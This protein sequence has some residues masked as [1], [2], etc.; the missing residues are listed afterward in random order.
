M[1]PRVVHCKLHVMA[2]AVVQ[3]N[4][5]CLIVAVN[6]AEHVSYSAEAI[7]GPLDGGSLR[8]KQFSSVG[9]TR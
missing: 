6:A 1:S 2:Q 8:C 9:W 3:L 7:V 4:R 5:Q